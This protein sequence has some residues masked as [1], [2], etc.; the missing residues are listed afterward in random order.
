MTRRMLFPLL[1]APALPAQSGA[2][3]P[4][5]LAKAPK[6]TLR[7]RIERVEITMG[8]GM[9][10]LELA[11]GKKTARVMLGSLRFLMEKNF[12]PKAGQ[13]AIVHGFE[14]EGFVIAREI[15]IPAEKVVL[16]LRE[17]D[18]TPLWRRQG[19]AGIRK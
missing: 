16:R 7:G 18:G 19:G 10:H 4:H 15:A 14:Q 2:G 13:E 12:N 5:P 8:K 1:A 3:V 6:V 17:E 9:P 11:V